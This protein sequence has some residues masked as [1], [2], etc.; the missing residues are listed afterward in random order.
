MRDNLI[1]YGIPEQ[2][3]GTEHG[4]DN[5]DVL[6]NEFFTKRLGLAGGDMELDRAHRLGH[7]ERSRKPRPIIVKFHRYKDREDVRAQANSMRN[8]LK[9]SNHG[10]GVQIPK[11]WRDARRPLYSIMQAERLRETE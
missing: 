1:L 10:V 3:Q 2:Q 8:D 4:A 6:A 9:S 7:P 11:E 5:S